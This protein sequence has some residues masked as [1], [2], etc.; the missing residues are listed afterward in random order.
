MRIYERHLRKPP[1]GHSEYPRP[2]NTFRSIS[3]YFD[4]PNSGSWADADAKNDGD[5]HNPVDD[6]SDKL[7]PMFRFDNDHAVP[8]LHCEIEGNT[9]A[10]WMD[11]I[12]TAAVGILVG[13]TFFGPL[14]GYIV[15]GIAWLL[16]RLLDWL[17][18]NDGDAGET[19][20]D[21]DDPNRRAGTGDRRG[22]RQTAC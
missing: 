21:W 20:V 9:I 11:D 22:G 7:N 17:T 13:C 8:Y 3:P 10:I 6:R 16:K 5:F 1:G 2:S 12:I 18:G 15:G 14:G 19:D 4:E